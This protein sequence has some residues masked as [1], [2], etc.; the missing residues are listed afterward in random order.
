MFNKKYIFSF[1]SLFYLV[2]LYSQQHKMTALQIITKATETYKSN[3]DINYN[4]TYNLYLDYKS[5]NVYEQYKGIVLKTKDV[6]Y[7]KVKNTEFVVFKKYAVK[8]NHDQ[9]AMIIGEKSTEFQQSPLSLINYL[10]GFKYRLINPNPDTFECELVPANKISQI[11]I[12]KVIL[13]IKK[14][15]FSLAK[16]TIFYVE[17]MESKNKKGQIVQSIP[18]L[19]ILFTKRSKNDKQDKLLLTQENYFTLINNNIVVSP[20][21]TKYKLFKS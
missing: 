9:K 16:Q 2:V 5:K 18:R 8:I 13:S 20:R 19:E 6:S 17:N 11:M 3:N 7:F 4:T 21:L 1:F 12:G 15:D 10:K 14:T